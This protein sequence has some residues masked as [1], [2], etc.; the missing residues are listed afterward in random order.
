MVPYFTITIQVMAVAF[1]STCYHNTIYAFFK[2]VQDHQGIKF[3]RA[4]QLN[5]LDLGWILK[6]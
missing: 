1:Q 2:N 3:T 5:D 6:S 4:R